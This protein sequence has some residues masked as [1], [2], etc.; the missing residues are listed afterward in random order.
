MPELAEISCVYR[1]VSFFSSYALFCKILATTYQQVNIPVE[2]I[3]EKIK[4]SI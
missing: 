3:Q 1:N 4:F 2:R